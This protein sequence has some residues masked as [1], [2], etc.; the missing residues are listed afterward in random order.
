MT[1][2]ARGTVEQPGTGVR[3]KAGLNRAI[4][5]QGL[6]RL[7]SAPGG[8]D[9]GVRRPLLRVRPV[10]HQPA[11]PGLRSTCSEAVPSAR[12]SVSGLRARRGSRRRRRA[13]RCQPGGSYAQRLGREPGGGRARG[14]TEEAESCSSCGQAARDGNRHWWGAF[15]STLRSDAERLSSPR[16][17]SFWP[18]AAPMTPP[19]SVRTGRSEWR[20]P[21][22]PCRAPAPLTTRGSAIS[23]ALS[24]DPPWR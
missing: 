1:R 2:S 8:E 15:L 6:G 5:D 24:L 7:R 21:R 23:I 19:H 16:S 10:R 18:N 4:L 20:Q 17:P 9:R 11:V 13:S 12:A 22:S 3:R 14:R